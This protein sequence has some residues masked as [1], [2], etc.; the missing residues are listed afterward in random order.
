MGSHAKLMSPTVQERGGWVRATPVAR[1]RR[2]SRPAAHRVLASAL[3]L[4]LIAGVS[5]AAT[6]DAKRP[7][8][9]SDIRKFIGSSPEGWLLAPPSKVLNTT[10]VGALGVGLKDQSSEASYSSVP[11][12]LRPAKEQ[13]RRI[14]NNAN[15]YALGG[16]WDEHMVEANQHADARLQGEDPR[17][18]ASQAYGLAVSISTGAYDPEIT[19][20][21]RLTAISRTV[22]MIDFVVRNHKANR[23]DGGGW[24]GEWQS[25]YWS[26]MTA[27][28]AW[29]LGNVVLPPDQLLIGRMLEAEANFT[30]YRP[31][32]Y[33][34]DR[35]G[36]ILTKGDSGAEELA[37]DG[38]GLF[39]AVELLPFNPKRAYWAAAAYRRMAAAYA[40][41]SDVNKTTVISGMDLSLWLN[42]SNIEENGLVVNHGR[43]NPDY[44]AQ[45]ELNLASA[46]LAPL[47]GD[48]IPDAARY[49][50]GLVY[51]SLSQVRFPNG[52]TIYQPNNM[53]INY[54]NGSSWGERRPIIFA[55]LDAQMR[56]LNFGTN[57]KPSPADW[58]KQHLSYVTRMQERSWTGETYQE[59]DDDSYPLRE[60]MV[61]AYAGLAWLTD[62]VAGKRLV[63]WSPASSA[64]KTPKTPGL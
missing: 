7:P 29:L 15:K 52:E 34:R 35:S 42:G 5:V 17:R 24:G 25:S 26:A 54:P 1:L 16:W 39:T 58:E 33:Y 2:V 61:S 22:Q 45:V 4:T 64:S 21:D 12:S 19:N 56:A 47:L 46:S 38:Y 36:K 43:L 51:S 62:Y 50:A 32:H 8:S 60:E 3:G 14:L 40:R 55:A 44:T 48:K 37:W 9:V 6:S 23:W 53:K 41:P 18:F 49:N 10:G 63:A 27:Q 59:G 13:W 28:A 31:L 20:V 11:P 30:M 57:L